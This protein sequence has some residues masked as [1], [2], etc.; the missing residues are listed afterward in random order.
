MKSRQIGYLQ[1][2]KHFSAYQEQRASLL[3][4]EEKHIHKGTLSSFKWDRLKLWQTRN[5]LPPLP[6][7]K[8]SETSTYGLRKSMGFCCCGQQKIKT[9]QWA[10]LLQGLIKLQRGTIPALSRSST[11]AIY[12]SEITHHRNNSWKSNDFPATVNCCK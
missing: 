9:I 6:L 10:F 12:N 3:V 5:I 4:L 7:K 2:K 8:V 11:A 1:P